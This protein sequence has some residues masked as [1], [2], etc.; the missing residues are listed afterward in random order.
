MSATELKTLAKLSK[1][2]WKRLANADQ[3]DPEEL[4]TILRDILEGID[5]L[6]DTAAPTE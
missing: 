5:R 3:E 4:L 1:A 6:E 2:G